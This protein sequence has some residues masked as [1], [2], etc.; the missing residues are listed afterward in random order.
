MTVNK[1]EVFIL[2]GPRSVIRISPQPDLFVSAQY[3]LYNAILTGPSNSGPIKYEVDTG[4]TSQQA[5]TEDEEAGTSECKELTPIEHLDIDKLLADAWPTSGDVTEE[6]PSQTHM[7]KVQLFDQVNRETFDENILFRSR[8]L[9]VTEAKSPSS[10]DEQKGIVEIAQLARADTDERDMESPVEVRV[11]NEDI[12]CSGAGPRH[13]PE[14]GFEEEGEEEHE[15]E[16]TT[17]EELK[18]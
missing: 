12:G 8:R 7:R 3:S 4:N 16:G 17:Q 9:K 5:A 10:E 18:T 15:R 13:E 14:S 1:D 11:E 6:C 2:E